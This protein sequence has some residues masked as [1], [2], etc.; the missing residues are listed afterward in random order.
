MLY[1]YVII[2]FNIYICVLLLLCVGPV[3]DDFQ[4]EPK[5]KSS[6]YSNCTNTNN[7]GSSGGLEAVSGGGGID[8]DME[9]N[10]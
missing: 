8:D 9:A 2:I 7:S 3:S 5:H 10:G 1:M 4:F 6:S